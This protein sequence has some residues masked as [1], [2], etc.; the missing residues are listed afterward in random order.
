[1]KRIIIVILACTLS[2]FL[3]SCDALFEST[4]GEEQIQ[5]PI[6]KHTEGEWIMDIEVT[7]ETEGLR[8]K[9]CTDCG[10]I[11]K[12]ETV[13][14]SAFGSKGL[15]FE[16]NQRKDGYILTSVGTCN[17]ENVVIPSTYEGL[18]VTNIGERAFEYCS[19]IISVEIPD[20]V[21]RIGEY[22]FYYCTSLRDVHIPESVKMIDEAAFACCVSIKEFN[23]SKN[24]SNIY[25]GSFMA[26]N[27]LEK[28]TVDEENPYFA[29]MDGNFYSKDHKI[30]IQYAIG[31]GKEHFEIPDTVEMIGM[32]AFA[33]C[34]DEDGNIHQN[35][36]QPTLKSIVI[37][38]S[39][40]VIQDEAFS[41]A[42]A[43]ESVEI[44][45]SVTIIGY[46]A[47]AFCSSLKNV[48]LPSSLVEI[49]YYAFAY[50]FSLD[51]NEYY[52][53][54]YLGNDE[55]PYLALIY[56]MFL[57]SDT[58]EIHP[59]TEIIADGAFVE[60]EYL[61]SI[62]IPDS[63][64]VIGHSAFAYCE[65]LKSVTL[66]NN[67]NVIGHYA[68]EGCSSLE[69]ITIPASVSDVGRYA[70]SGCTSL[71]IYS[72]AYTQPSG[73]NVYWNPNFRPVIWKDIE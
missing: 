55:N 7:R 10:E 14:T 23:I 52:D 58:M 2:F 47:F 64:R 71:T 26:C 63:V 44:P 50:C 53:I 9:E 65:S 1:M 21:L 69:E 12:S 54:C 36:K 57:Y 37:P 31:N 73:W 29:S 18:P 22:A 46:Y 51:F 5:A 62:E 60:C 32:G 61:L 3:A 15:E 24:L 33:S 34:V 30:L 17:D 45:D 48:S 13:P 56:P 70:F 66:G 20:T 39:V 4:D 68:F 16:F 40:A 41:G 28:F 49:G 19:N 27:S 43:L 72:E 25:T 59:D 42:A 67:L 35:G 11:L 6:H 8:H 38:E